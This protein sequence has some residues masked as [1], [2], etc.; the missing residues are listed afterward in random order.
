MYTLST[1][2]TPESGRFPLLGTCWSL[3]FASASRGRA[4]LE[5][6][7]GDELLDIVVPTSLRPGLLRGAHTDACDGHELT[8]A[9]GVLAEGSDVP[10]EQVTFTRG[11]LRATHRDREATAVRGAFWISVSEGRH[12]S[13]AVTRADG[14]VERRRVYR[15][16]ADASG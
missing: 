9:W 6:Y 3:R 8:F 12:H 13:V 16:S 7:C 11:R 5:V 4:A 2:E 1:R 15:G 10:P 14:T